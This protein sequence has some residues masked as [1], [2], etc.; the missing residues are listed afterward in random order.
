MMELIPVSESEESEQWSCLKCCLLGRHTDAV[1]ILV[2]EDDGDVVKTGLCGN[3][4]EV[5]VS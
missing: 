5:E 4:A 2:D 3:H 1:V